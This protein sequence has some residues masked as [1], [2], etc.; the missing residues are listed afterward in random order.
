M[1]GPSWLERLRGARKTALLQDGKRKVHYL[2][3]DGLEMAEEYNL[4]TSQL[5]AR[6][7]REKN[8]LGSC[9][10]WQV[11]VGEPTMHPEGALESELIKESSSSVRKVVLFTAVTRPTASQT[12]TTYLHEEGYSDQFPVADPEPTLP[13]GGLQHLCGE[14][15]ALLCCPHHQQKVSITR[16]SPF[17]TW[18]D[19]S[20]PWTRLP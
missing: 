18:T 8:A 5:L 11:E 13:Q 10:K 3:E 17:L 20:F 15:A 12:A 4:K 7:W 14:G 2:F 6:K 16:S 19:S 9:G 1:A